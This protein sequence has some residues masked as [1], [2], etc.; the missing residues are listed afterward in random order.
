MVQ[1]RKGLAAPP[2]PSSP[3]GDVC[4]FVHTHSCSGI[5]RL[6]CLDKQQLT[7]GA[8]NVLRAGHLMYSGLLRVIQPSNS[9]AG[10]AQHFTP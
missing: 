5:T 8:A 2:P 7:Q 4:M 6:A 3:V 1:G 9:S 10:S